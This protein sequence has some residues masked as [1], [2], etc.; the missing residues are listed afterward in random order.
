MNVAPIRAVLPQG[1]QR[2]GECFECGSRDHYRN[3]CPRWVGQQVQVA[4]HPNQLQMVGPNQNRGQ[5]GH[6][7]Q[8]RGR[9]F[10]ANANEA[11]N[12]PNVVAGTFYLNGHYATVLFDSGADYSLVSSNFVHLIDVNPC[13][14]N[15][16]LD[17]EMV[18]G[19]LTRLSQILRD[20]VLTLDDV[21]FFID[22][23][24]LDIGSFDVIVGMDWLTAVNATIDCGERVVKIPLSSGRVLR[25]QGEISDSS[26]S[27]VFSA[28]VTKVGLKTLEL[29]IGRASCRE[30]VSECV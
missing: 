8:P 22:L 28:T 5:Q 7:V 21:E 14:L 27:K 2:R 20:C 15:C 26:N 1:N 16:V 19:S 6:Q 12:D 10:A 30:R 3:N 25:V 23:M 9:A 13:S 11:R 4:V 18:N 17:I 29:E 24:P